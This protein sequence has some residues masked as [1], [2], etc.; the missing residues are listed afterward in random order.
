MLPLAIFVI[1]F[2]LQQ[3]NTVPLIGIKL[4]TVLPAATIKGELSLSVRTS[5]VQCALILCAEEVHGTYVQRSQ[6]SAVGN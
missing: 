1:F 3:Q 5:R 2:L 6:Y 4:V